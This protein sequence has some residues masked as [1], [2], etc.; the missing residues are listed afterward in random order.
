[1][2][3]GN[4]SDDGTLAKVV[5]V[6]GIDKPLDESPVVLTVTEAVERTEED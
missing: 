1:M 6:V 2:E 3:D 5:G 4:N